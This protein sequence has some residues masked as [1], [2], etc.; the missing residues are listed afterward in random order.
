HL[1]FQ[2]DRSRHR[3]CPGG[4]LGRPGNSS[5]QK[6]IGAS[7]AQSNSNTTSG[8]DWVGRYTVRGAFDVQQNAHKF[9][10]MV[11]LIE[12]SWDAASSRKGLGICNHQVVRVRWY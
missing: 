5:L 3:Q 4:A 11:H 10:I 6:W 9:P 7:Q 2:M 12:N 1:R 8:W